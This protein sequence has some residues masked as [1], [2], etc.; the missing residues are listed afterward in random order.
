MS[1]LHMTHWHTRTGNVLSRSVK[2]SAKIWIQMIQMKDAFA[3]FRQLRAA[4]MPVSV[5]FW[6]QTAH[7]WVR[8][9]FVRFMVSASHSTCPLQ[10]I[11][12]HISNCEIRNRTGCTP[13]T[14]I[15]RYRRLQLFGYIARSEPETDHRRALHA[16]IRGPPAECWLEKTSRASGDQERHGLELL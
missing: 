11:S 3:N 10:P 9:G 13:A 6:I 14:D 16:T 2:Q 8:Q 1:W 4:T 15:I 5:Q 7:L 12:H